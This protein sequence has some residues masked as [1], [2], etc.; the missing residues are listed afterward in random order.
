MCEP[1]Y[2]V[3]VI[4]YLGYLWHAGLRYINVGIRAVVLISEH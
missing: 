4:A 2:I 3:S 1:L